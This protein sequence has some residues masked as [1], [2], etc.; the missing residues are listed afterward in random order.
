MLSIIYQINDWIN[1][2]ATQPLND[3]SATSFKSFYFFPTPSLCG[4]LGCYH[5]VLRCIPLSPHLLWC[6][7]KSTPIQELEHLTETQ[8]QSH[9]ILLQTLQWIPTSL[10]PIQFCLPLPPLSLNPSS[11]N[12]PDSLL[13]L[14]PLQPPP[15]ISL[16][17]AQSYISF[18]SQI[19]VSP[20]D[21]G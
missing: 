2:G 10:S 20:N 5:A 3:T 19:S 12:T 21:T 14:S 4:S 11:C 15:N 13:L 7:L 16:C 9:H 8:I 18:S 17:L 6:F 1:K